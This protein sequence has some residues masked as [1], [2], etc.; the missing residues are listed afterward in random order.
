MFSKVALFTVAT[1]AVFAAAAPAPG[2]INNS[3]NTG[4]VQCCNQLLKSDDKQATL[5]A[6]LL[7][8]VLGPVTT[9]V[10]LQCSPLSVIGIGSGSSCSSQPVCCSDNSF[11]GLVAVGCSPINL[12]I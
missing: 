3:C 2:G 9:Q 5:L 6:S 12:N 1:M 4:P 10:G 8:L 7:G 11:N